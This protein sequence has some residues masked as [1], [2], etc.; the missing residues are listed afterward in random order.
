MQRS[1]AQKTPR[2]HT[3]TDGNGVDPEYLFD[4]RGLFALSEAGDNLSSSVTG[5]AAEGRVLTASR[6]HSEFAK[7]MPD[8][9]SEKIKK[10]NIPQK[11]VTIK[12][13]KQAALLASGTGSNLS[14]RDEL[15]WIAAAIADL[16]GYTIV[17]DEISLPFYKKINGVTAI[18]LQQFETQE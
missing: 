4:L 17:T 18:T 6:I 14:S 10:I 8:E 11:R 7:M 15:E 2:T 13:D 12:Y 3:M 16:H 1:L 5:A 9:A